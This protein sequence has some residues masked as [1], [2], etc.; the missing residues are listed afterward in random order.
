[1]IVLNHECAILWKSAI[2][3]CLRYWAKIWA[4]VGKKIKAPVYIKIKKLFKQG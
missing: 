3:I 4:S 1:V 2:D